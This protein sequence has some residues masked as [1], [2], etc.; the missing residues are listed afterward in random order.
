MVRMFQSL[1]ESVPKMNSNVGV[2]N[3]FKA[4]KISS[5]NPDEYL[6]ITSKITLDTVSST[7]DKLNRLM[8][9]NLPKSSKYKIMKEIEFKNVIMCNMEVIDEDEDEYYLGTSPYGTLKELS[10]TRKTSIEC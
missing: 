2:A 4:Q 9:N 8:C 7:L 5:A 3:Y 1:Y 10:I 6:A